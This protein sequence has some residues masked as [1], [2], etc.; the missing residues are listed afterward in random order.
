[1]SDSVSSTDE[2][3][4]G[5]MS[6]ICLAATGLSVRDMVEQIETH[7][8]E[9]SMVELRID[10]L[11]EVRKNELK[12]LVETLQKRGQ[13]VLWT[14]RWS[15]ETGAFEGSEQERLEVLELGDQLGADY[16]DVELKSS[17]AQRLELKRAK[18]ILSHHNFERCPE[19]YEIEALIA[20]AKELNADVLKFAFATSSTQECLRVMSIYK[21]V[22][23]QPAIAIA[24]GEFGAPSRLFGAFLGMPW[25][26]AAADGFGGTAPGQYSVG[27]LVELYRYEGLQKETRRFAVIG[28]PVSHSLSPNIHNRHYISEGIDAVYGKIKVDDILAFYQLADLIGLDGV[29]VTVPHK[30]SIAKLAPR[31]S[32]LSKVG[33]ANTLIRKDR[34]AWKVEN[35]DIA[36]AIASIQAQ[37][38]EGA[39]SPRVLI[40][41]AGGVARALAFGMVDRGWKVTA[42]NRSPERLEQLAKELPEIETLHWDDRCAHGFDVVVNGT[43]LGMTP[44]EDR[45]P[46]EFEG[47]HLGLVVFDT[48]YTPEQTLFLRSARDAGAHIATGREMFYRQ[49]ALQ[50]QH[51][52]GDAAPWDSMAEILQDLQNS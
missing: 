43:S 4:S 9:V 52:F 44:H 38:D 26:Y 21:K 50:H 8:G 15:E 20:E 7:E 49:A 30:E 39:S 31:Q 37:L 48:V 24:M 36:A 18:K 23:D 1:M 34:R 19:E 51:W 5:P 40:L 16:V 41:G 14:V 29:S 22:G 3:T 25:T 13:K 45:T 46:M 47:G 32:Y 42:T 10:A 11:Q 12:P 17:L 27:E 28:N 2:Q 35:T 33:S 6:S